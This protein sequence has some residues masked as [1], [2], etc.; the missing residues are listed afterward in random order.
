MRYCHAPPDTDS[1]E[2]VVLG[3]AERL[4]L[5]GDVE[6]G[7]T[8]GMRLEGEEASRMLRLSVYLAPTEL[9]KLLERRERQRQRQV[10]KD[11]NR[12]AQESGVNLTDFDK[13]ALNEGVSSNLV[14]FYARNLTLC[15]F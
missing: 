8:F 11:A 15:L 10:G 7:T 4:Q 2:Y 12:A 1:A 9:H 13:W 3:A 5:D 14:F 6:F